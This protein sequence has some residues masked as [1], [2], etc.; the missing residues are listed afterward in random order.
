MVLTRH[1]RGE[2]DTPPKKMKEEADGSEEPQDGDGA[3]RRPQRQMAGP[4]AR[5]QTRGRPGSPTAAAS[6][7]ADTL[8]GAMGVSCSH[9]RRSLSRFSDSWDGE[10]RDRELKFTGS[11]FRSSRHRVIERLPPSRRRYNVEFTEIEV[12]RSGRKRKMMYDNFSDTWITTQ[13]AHSGRQ[14][15]AG[16]A[17]PP[18]PARP[19]SEPSPPTPPDDG[20]A[21]RRAEPSSRRRVLLPPLPE[22][23][24]MDMYS[25]VKRIHR[26]A[27]RFGITVEEPGPARRVHRFVG[28]SSSD[29][30]EEEEE[31]AEE[32][33]DAAGP[34]PGEEQR[35]EDRPPEQRLRPRAARSAA[36]SETKVIKKY[37]LRENRREPEFYQDESLQLPRPRELREER[38][39]HPSWRRRRHHRKNSAFNESTT[40]SSSGRDSGEDSFQRRKARS[41][42]G[43]RNKCLP[44]NFSQSEAS[45]RAGGSE[46]QRV[47]NSLADVDPMSI[48]RTVNFDTIGGLKEHIRDLKEMILLPL[49]YPE[50][51]SSKNITPPKGVLFCGPPG[52]GKTLMARALANECSVGDRKVAF[53]MRKGAD[54]L[55]KWVGESERQLRLLFDQA[56]QMRPSIIFFDEV[57]GLAPVRSSKQDYIHASIVSTLLALMDGVDSRGE[58]IVIGATNR[59][60]SV[61]PA[62]RRPGRF[63]RE[64]H[65]PLPPLESREQILRIQLGSWRPPV[66]EPTVCWLA[67]QTAGY[68]GADLK[69]LVTEAVLHALRERY[70]QIYGSK[71]RLLIDVDQ[72]QVQPS[73][74]R[75][76]MA[77]MTPAGQR[78]RTEERR[79][80]PAAV[81]PLLAAPLAA[82]RAALRTAFPWGYKQTAAELSRAE[83]YMPRLLLAGRP[84]QCHTEYLAPALLHG[85]ENV[86]VFTFN[87]FSLHASGGDPLTTLSQLLSEAAR[88]T[89]SV[90]YLPR[91]DSLW[92]YL[93]GRLGLRE[94]LLDLLRDLP[95]RAPLLLLA[96]SDTEPETGRVPGEVAAL[97]SAAR[98]QLLTVYDPSVEHRRQLFTRLFM[99][100][101]IMLKK[102][103]NKHVVPE[104]LPVAPPP[105]PRQ[106]SESELQQLHRREERR[107]AELRI[108]LRE[109]CGRLIRNRQF[110]LFRQPVEED[111][112]PDYYSIIE[113]PMDLDTIMTR[114]DQHKYEAAEDFLGD[115]DL[116]CTNALE[117]NPDTTEVGREIRHRACML[118]DQAHKLIAEQLD[119]DFEEQ[120]KMIRESRRQRAESPTKFAPSY[121]VTPR[122][123]QQQQ[124]Q[125]QQVVQSGGPAAAAESATP[126]ARRPHRR[127]SRWS[128]GQVRSRKRKRPE[129][130]SGAGG[131]EP[132]RPE[133]GRERRL[134][135][136]LA[137]ACAGQ[138]PP[139]EG[140]PS[141]GQEAVA[142][143]AAPPDEDSGHGSTA[144]ASDEQLGKVAAGV[145]V[146][147]AR[148]L[149]LCERSV[150]LTAGWTVAELEELHDRLAATVRRFAFRRQ[151]NDMLK[152]MEDILGYY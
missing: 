43:F 117:Y 111:D 110:E 49:L 39:G 104:E 139:A 147:R 86:R 90:V 137:L 138:S 24:G 53:F 118:R 3:E 121:L 31:V 14:Q 2:D 13:I 133:S 52:T 115:V 41:M 63:D 88:G 56:Y 84:G 146:D 99:K 25:R 129:R 42:Q 38:F 57:D 97:F 149:A 66:P 40:D 87:A 17:P 69:H 83:A 23:D 68:C 1:S 71:Q 6:G 93:A 46:R 54:V 128:Q 100:R 92:T 145:Q 37:Y 103:K 59:P 16:D 134:S 95:R 96:T 81:R 28:D 73:H 61:D 107:L 50:V 109:M 136:E 75:A 12:R 112:A 30:D 70:P 141:P 11:P 20:E 89:P 47:G 76:A 132:E 35:G 21:E 135:G 74:F 122:L 62:L 143:K 101:A 33:E 80:L 140:G 7:S 15:L 85:L 131:A 102:R 91:L 18:P 114:I 151:R 116:I 8:G 130:D 123:Y 77:R 98:Q 78:D 120:C 22:D 124:Q 4:A 152:E 67:R 126:S 113:R 148:L 44:M 106:L 55:S 29:S 105:P 125:Q 5:R 32:A 36:R 64:F 94:P 58:V 9:S 65:F 51:F 82:A 48:D 144:A 119:S 108:F 27:Q 72:I 127:H 150:S 34:P 60:D 10:R 19:R 142:A 79:L 26:P 45:Q